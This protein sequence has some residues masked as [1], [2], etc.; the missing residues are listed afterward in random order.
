MA[1]TIDL[2]EC[3]SC[4]DCEPECPTGAIIDGA[5][6][7]E[8]NAAKCTECDDDPDSIRC[9]EACLIDGAILPA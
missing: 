8:I 7:F 2:D 4:G 1:M 9:V 3:T 6:G 5:M